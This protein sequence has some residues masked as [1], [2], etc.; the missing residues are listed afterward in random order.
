MPFNT[1]TQ[2]SSRGY[3]LAAFI[4]N[5][6]AL[7]PLTGLLDYGLEE[8][9]LRTGNTLGGILA[10]FLGDTASIMVATFS[11]YRAPLIVTTSFLTGSLLLNLLLVLGTGR[12]SCS[13]IP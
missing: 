12:F 2:Q 1:D 13:E 5:L 10:A 6:I 9:Y 3:F 11:L 8:V 4:V 7:V